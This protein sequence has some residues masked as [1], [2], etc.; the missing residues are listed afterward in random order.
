LI[1]VKFIQTDP[2]RC[3]HSFICQTQDEANQIIVLDL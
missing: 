2:L 1:W 3:N